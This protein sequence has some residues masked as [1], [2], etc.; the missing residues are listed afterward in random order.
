MKLEPVIRW[1]IRDR[2]SLRI[3]QHGIT[4]ERLAVAVRSGNTALA[5]AIN[6][7]QGQLADRGDLARL[8]RRWFGDQPRG[9]EILG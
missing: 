6:V 2:P 8:G 7:A 9:T 4:D 1:L 5:D 3:V